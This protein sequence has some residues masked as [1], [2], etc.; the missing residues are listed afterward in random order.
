MSGA[1]KG[2]RKEIAGT[3]TERGAG[4]EKQPKRLRPEQVRLLEKMD[5]YSKPITIRLIPGQGIQERY[6]EQKIASYSCPISAEL[7]EEP[8][9]SPGCKHTFEKAAIKA[10]AATAGRHGRHTC[11]ECRQDR[12]NTFDINT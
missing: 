11:P 3:S 1:E 9:T 8:V 5:I 6:I 7:M 10:W 4:Q 2:K 12:P